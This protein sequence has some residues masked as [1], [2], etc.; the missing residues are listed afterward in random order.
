MLWLG[1]ITSVDSNSLTMLVTVLTS[2]KTLGRNTSKT[3]ESLSG[4]GTDAQNKIFI[5][6]EVHLK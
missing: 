4:L 5:D 3:A 1:C 2:L 6:G